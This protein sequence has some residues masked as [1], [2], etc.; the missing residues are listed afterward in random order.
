MIPDQFGNKLREPKFHIADVRTVFAFCVLLIFV[1]TWGVKIF[2][3]LRVC[4]DMR[5]WDQVLEPLLTVVVLAVGSVIA[6]FFTREHG[7]S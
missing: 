6:Y 3:C 2:E 7:E 1:A 4:N 5:D